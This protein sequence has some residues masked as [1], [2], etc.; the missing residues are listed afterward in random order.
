MADNDLSSEPRL[1]D[2]PRIA[3]VTRRF[4]EL[5]G[6]TLVVFGASLILGSVIAHTMPAGYPGLLLQA[7]NLP[8]LFF[9]LATVFLQR[10]YRHTF[11]Q[12]VSTSR[13]Q[14]FAMM[15]VLSLMLGGMIDMFVPT[16]RPAPSVAALALTSWSIWIVLR[17]WRWRIHYVVPAAA[18]IIAAMITATAPPLADYWV[19]IDPARTTAYLLS[20]SL[21]GL[22]MVTA[23]LFDHRLLASS[24][25]PRA[26]AESGARRALARAGSGGMRAAFAV[27]VCL[28]TGGA[29]WSASPILRHVP[30]SL[31]LIVSVVAF[32]MLLAMFQISRAVTGGALAAAPP[33]LTLHL[34]SDSL[35]LMF[36]MALAAALESAIGPRGLTLL[37][38]SIGSASA[39]VAVRD[40]PYRGHY[41]IGAV[42]SAVALLVSARVEPARSLTILVFATSGALMLEG[43]L[44]HFVATRNHRIG[45]V[46]DHGAVNVDTI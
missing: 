6:L 14:F 35:A 16:G 10:M 1:G 12:A 20:F 39:W 40:W 5:Q 23:G 19:A 25:G 37:A 34:G 33:V 11:G 41:L 43:L 8:G 18:G 36:V 22:G 28:T 31:L 2:I 46:S 42:A 17:D 7:W 27:M 26:S 21:L 32:Q 29:L 3:F 45:G 30:L 24:L 13:Q 15:P 44:D 9:V 4:H 38:I